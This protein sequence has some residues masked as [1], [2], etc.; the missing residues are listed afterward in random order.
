ME[1]QL[2]SYEGKITRN[3]LAQLTTPEGTRTHRPVPHSCLRSLPGV[4]DYDETI[5]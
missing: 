1:S 4:R 5:H 2:M 3:Q